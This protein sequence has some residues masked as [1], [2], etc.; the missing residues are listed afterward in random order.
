[1]SHNITEALPP[2]SSAPAARTRKR[3]R[4]FMWAFIAIQVLFLV[5]LIAAIAGSSHDPQAA[6]T[7]AQVCGHGRWQGLYDSHAQCVRQYGQDL[8]NAYD[9]GRGI[10]AMLFIG[11][12]VATD[13]I[14]GIGRLIVLTERRR[15]A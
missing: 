10:G 13:V 12:W 1:M 11:L 15:S 14:L 9:A 6:H 2:G 7:V 4:V 3:R 8:H 5:L